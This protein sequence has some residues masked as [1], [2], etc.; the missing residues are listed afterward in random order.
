MKFLAVFTTAGSCDEACRNASALVARR[1]VSI[2]EYAVAAATGEA[3]R[4]S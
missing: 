2:E 1:L 4:A 3:L